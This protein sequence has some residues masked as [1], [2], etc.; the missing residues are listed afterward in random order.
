MA[1]TER[2]KLVR[3]W[4]NT[5]DTTQAADLDFDPQAAF[6]EQPANM[7]Q[8]AKSIE[9]ARSHLVDCQAQLLKAETLLNRCIDAYEEEEKRRGLRG[10]A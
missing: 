6:V 5:P 9:I 1:A 10:R 2:G 8:L 3:F 7:E 4:R